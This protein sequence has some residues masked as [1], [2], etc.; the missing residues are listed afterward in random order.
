MIRHSSVK[1]I[2]HAVAAAM[3]LLVSSSMWAADATPSA[4]RGYL[5]LQSPVNVAGTQLQSGK[6]RVEWTGPADQ[7][8][9]KIY[10]GSKAVVS[11]HARLVNDNP[12][13]DH[14]GYTAGENGTKSLTQI[15]FGK[16]KCSLRLENEST[17]SDAQRAAK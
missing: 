10:S 11:T 3:V 2:L 4:G 14:L 12:S 1:R 9:V 7:V 6:Y 8:E 16:Q 5:E 13:Y 15:S 17:N